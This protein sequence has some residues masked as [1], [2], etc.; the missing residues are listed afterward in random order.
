MLFRSVVDRSQTIAQAQAYWRERAAAGT[1]PASLARL[2]FMAGDLLAAVPV[3]ASAKDAYLLSAVL[4]GMDDATAVQ[5][6]RTAAAAAAPQGA[7]LVVLEMIMP[8]PQ[9]DLATAA[10]DMQMFMATTGRERTCDEWA[11]LYAQ[12]GLRW[13]ET[14]AL[15]GFGAM[16]VLKAR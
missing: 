7:T 16:M 13:V 1:A 11:R 9:A 10:F 4:H 8:S 12:A 15:A 2:Q 6:L 3:A 5:A 14:V